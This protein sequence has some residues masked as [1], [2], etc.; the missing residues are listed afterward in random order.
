M[1]IKIALVGVAD[2]GKT[3]LA[4]A[5]TKQ[6][7]SSVYNPTCGMDLKIYRDERE[8]IKMNIW[9]LA[10]GNQYNT[11]VDSFVPT[12][13]WIVLCFSATSIQSYYESF[14]LYNRL[15]RE[16]VVF[17]ATKIDLSRKREYED[18]SD[19]VVSLTGKPVIY[20]SA[21]YNIGI[22]PLIDYLT[23][24]SVKKSGKV[25]FQLQDEVYFLKDANEKD[26]KKCIIV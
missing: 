12:C 10:G 9:D 7:F 17:V 2:C 5:M 4:Q 23:L 1:Q 26:D 24:Y 22:K 15:E 20:T 8:G 25:R 11:I 18:W 21:K 14:K 16:R 6:D 19:E 3:C 13:D